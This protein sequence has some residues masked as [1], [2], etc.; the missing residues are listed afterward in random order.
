MAIKKYDVDIKLYLSA[1]NIKTFTVKAN[2]ERKARMIAQKEAI[3]KF[4]IAY[5]HLLQIV[6]VR[7]H[8]E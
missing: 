8:T 3:K 1:N 5:P 7:L 4:S 2:S 6:G